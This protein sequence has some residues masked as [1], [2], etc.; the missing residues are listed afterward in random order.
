MYVLCNMCFKLLFQQGPTPAATLEAVRAV[1]LHSDAALRQ[2]IGG[3]VP[4]PKAVLM[5]Q[6]EKALTAAVKCGDDGTCMQQ[7]R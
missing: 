1:R 2:A 3:Q 6:A 5:L 7:Q 4:S